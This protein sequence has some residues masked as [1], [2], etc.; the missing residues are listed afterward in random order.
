MI[1]VFFM[2]FEPGIAWEKIALARRGQ[3][4]ILTTYL[5]PYVLLIT[6]LEGWGLEKWG[7]WQSKFQK[8]RDF[9]HHEVIGY[10]AIQFVLLLAMVYIAGLLILRVSQTFHGRNTYLQAFT[11]AAYGFSPV[12]LWRLLDPI[13]TMNPWVTWG[14]GVA[15]MIWI[16]YQGVPRVIQPDPTHAFGLYLSTIFVMVLTSGMVRLVT[17][18]FLTGQSSFNHSWL[19]RELSH[20]LSH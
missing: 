4:Y 5:L 14:M 18:M 15:M 20:F 2:I 3:L 16:L 8:F 9:T 12:F 17:A 1:K 7:K 11:L 10:E 19:T 6:L 13:P